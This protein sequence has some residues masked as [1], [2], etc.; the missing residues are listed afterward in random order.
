V[1]RHP[2]QHWGWLLFA[3]ALIAS[4]IAGGILIGR[5]LEAAPAD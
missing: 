3:L 1:L 5:R 4:L 2:L